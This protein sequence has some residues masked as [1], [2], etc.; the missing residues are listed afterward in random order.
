MA[1]VSTVRIPAKGKKDIDAYGRVQN[2]LI[3]LCRVGAAK[4]NVR[5]V[6]ERVK[7]SGERVPVLEISPNGDVA[8]IAPPTLK[9][10]LADKFPAAL[11]QIGFAHR[12]QQAAAPV[13]KGSKRGGKA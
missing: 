6:I 13:K 5:V 2:K 1:P 12:N 8:E 10:S 3:D 11:R 4:D 7:P 9:S